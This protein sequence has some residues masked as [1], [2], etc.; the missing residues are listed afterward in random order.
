MPEIELR[1]RMEQLS[2]QIEDPGLRKQ[3]RS[4][5]NCGILNSAG[6]CQ[7][8]GNYI[9]DEL[10]KTG[11]G[12]RH[13]LEEA[14]KFVMNVLLLPRSDRGEKQISLISD[15]PANRPDSPEHFRSRFISLVDFAVYTLRAAG[16]HRPMG[17]VNQ[18]K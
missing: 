8:W 6:R 9:L 16:I 7:S 4:M 3:F 17:A 14:L 10:V 15:F 2:Q 13:D 1:H 11:V 12:N 5:I 18:A